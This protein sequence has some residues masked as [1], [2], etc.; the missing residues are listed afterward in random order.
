MNAVGGDVGFLNWES[1]VPPHA[2]L[3]EGS[4]KCQRGTERGTGCDEG[5]AGK[6][7]T[8]CRENVHRSPPSL[9]ICL[10][11]WYDQK[12]FIGLIRAGQMYDV[13]AVPPTADETLEI[14]WMGTHHHNVGSHMKLSAG[15]TRNPL[16]LEHVGNTESLNV[17]RPPGKVIFHP[18]KENTIE[19]SWV[20]MLGAGWRTR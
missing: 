14:L 2:R 10:T 5:P 16:A 11:N 17:L 8:W 7:G 6:Y 19:T 3:T 9:L 18:L 15:D 1:D 13:G 4:I 20:V 12:P